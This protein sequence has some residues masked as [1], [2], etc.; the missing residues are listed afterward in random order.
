MQNNT[1]P[2]SRTA[3]AI[4]R[5]ERH[6]IGPGALLETPSE[7]LLAPHDVPAFL[8][9]AKTHVPHLHSACPRLA[10]IHGAGCG[11]RRSEAQISAFGEVIER[12][13]ATRCCVSDAVLSTYRKLDYPSIHPGQFAL[14]DNQQYV[15]PQFH[16]QSLHED[17]ELPWVPSWSWTEQQVVYVPACFVYQLP[18]TG[19]STCVFHSVSTGLACASDIATARLS[20]LCEVIERDAIMIAWL[21]GLRLPRLQPVPEDPVTRHP[22]PSHR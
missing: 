7:I 8:Y 12:Y 10:P 21:Y 20:G 18:C 22:L 4:Q 5:V 17:V 16:F 6:L 2:P 11:L 9:A 3:E 13:S 1:V 19:T 15:Q 14:F